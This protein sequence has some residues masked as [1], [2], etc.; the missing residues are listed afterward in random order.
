MKKFYLISF[1]CLFFTS[2]NLYAVKAIPTPIEVRQPDCTTLTIRLYGDENFHYNTTEDGFLIVKN[3]QDAFVYATVSQ[4]GELQPTERIARNLNA[5]SASDVSF[6]RTLDVNKDISRLRV[7][8]N[9]MQTQEEAMQQMAPPPMQR[10]TSYIGEQ[11]LLVIL[12]NF[13]DK[14]FVYPQSNFVNL[15]NQT[16]YNYNGSTGS[17]R[18]YFMSSSYGKFKP[19]FDVVGPYTVSNTMA[20]Y[21]Q[22]SGG[23]GNDIRPAYMVVEACNLAHNDGVDFS[24]YDYNNDGYVDNVFIIYAGLNQAEGGPANTIWPHRWSIMVGSNVPSGTNITFD[25]KKLKDYSCSS[26][27]RGSSGTTMC[28]IGTFC[29]EFSHV[30]GLPDLYNTANNWD[31]NLGQW[32]IMDAGCY[33]GPGSNGDIPAMYS[34]YEMFY[35]GWFVPEILTMCDDY[36]LEP[37]HG[38]QKK[39][40]LVSKNNNHNLNGQ[41]PNPTEFYMIEN[42]QKIFYDAYLPGS[43]LLIT[44]VNYSYSKW[45]YNTVN[46]STLKGV[47]IIKANNSNYG[48]SNWGFPYSTTNSY[49]FQSATGSNPN[50]EK[51]ISQIEKNELNITFNFQQTTCPSES[52][53]AQS[54]NAEI[55][56]NILKNKQNTEAP[57]CVS[58]GIKEVKNN[59]FDVINYPLDWY[60]SMNY[61]N[62]SMEI[63]AINGVLL[64]TFNFT[65]EVS[66]A[67]ND[68]PNGVYLLKINDL[69][70]NKSYFSKA[71]K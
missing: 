19:T 4:N 37:L 35:L 69:S 38:S 62:Y 14:S 57:N 18:D 52:Q 30:L 41:S 10:A 3:Q 65:N 45:E 71:I 44:R 39:A 63:Y 23:T 49:N 1:A 33:N 21:G 15:T 58:T 51:N 13:T 34:A 5:R 7:I 29:H 36:L 55:K 47:E 32:D 2:I 54:N 40:Y 22:D 16:G 6:L 64:K 11:H 46:N 27:L 8:G 56:Q 68:F 48:Q 25:G 9:I 61:G 59:E 28:N 17:V 66:I 43:G 31:T 26:E 50:W 70:S 12:V 42:R 20:Y 24:K 67:K 60:I 53:V